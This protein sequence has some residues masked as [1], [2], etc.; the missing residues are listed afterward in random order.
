MAGRSI[1]QIE[2][3]DSMDSLL[4]R[5]IKSIRVEQ[6][7]WDIN[8][9]VFIDTNGVLWNSDFNQKPYRDFPQCYFNLRDKLI[10]AQSYR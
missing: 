2:S 4:N 3:E 10:S 7:G 9:K 6:D 1:I 5:F 8:N